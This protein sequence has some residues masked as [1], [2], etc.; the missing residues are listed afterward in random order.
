[1]SSFTTAQRAA[2][3]RNR[4]VV[5]MAGAGTGKTSTLVERCV[6]RLLNPVEPLSLDEILMVTFTEAAA[7]EMKERIRRRLD[8]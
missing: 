7:L 3:E 4:N 6:T 2:I 5:V 8:Q 1:M